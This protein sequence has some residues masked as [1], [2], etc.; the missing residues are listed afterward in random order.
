MK[1]LLGDK[2][3]AVE[4][5]LEDIHKVCRSSAVPTE[6]LSSTC[7]LQRAWPIL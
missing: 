6:Q 1:I 7:S 3:E 4:Q 2:L 5:Q